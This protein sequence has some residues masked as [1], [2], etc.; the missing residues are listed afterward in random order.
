MGDYAYFSQYHGW[1]EELT[2]A[3]W[4]SHD[5]CP[6]LM[7]F[8]VEEITQLELLALS[9]AWAWGSMEKPYGDVAFLLIA[10]GKTIEGEMAFGLAAMWAHPHQACICSLDEV[11]RKLALLINLAD[12][13]AYT[14]VQLNE[15]AQHVPL[16]NEGHLSAMVDG[17]SCRSV[18][19]HL[20]QLEVCRLLQYGDQV[21]Y[22]KGLNEGL[23]PVL[24]SLSGTLTQGIDMLGEPAHKPSFLLVDLS[25]VT[26]GD[27]MPEAPVS[28]ST[29][30][31][32]S[33][34]HLTM[35][36]PLKHMATS[37]WQL[38]SKNSIHRLCWPPPVRHWRTPPQRG[39]HLWPWELHLPPEWKTPASW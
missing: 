4:G 11:L 28:C 26:L 3:L 7:Q 5:I 37:A 23:E 14:F 30:T 38:R 34:S 16:S 9:H 27:H 36:H 25:Q 22:P 6:S 33:L 12:K 15:D 1:W 8:K 32:P 10:P 21:V 24:T 17:A 19:R 20:Y 2:E 29:L 18:C 39:Q 31:Q 13:W 35:E